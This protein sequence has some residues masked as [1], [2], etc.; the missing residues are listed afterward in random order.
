MMH[1]IVSKILTLAVMASAL[2]LGACKPE[3]GRAPAAPAPKALFGSKMIPRASLF[4]PPLQYQGRISP[5][6][7]KVSWLSLR[8]GAL[9][10]FI[11]DA[12]KPASA[13]QITHSKNG[14]GVH[15][16]SPN[17]AFIVFTE[18]LDNNLVK[19]WSLDVLSGERIALGPV[20]DGI[21]VFLQKVSGNWPNTALVAIN[22]RDPKWDDLYRINLSTG[23][24]KLVT[25]N[26]GFY[27]WVADDDLIPRIGIRKNKDKSDDWFLI[28]NDGSIK[29]LFHVLPQDV[30]GT[31]PLRFDPSG[32]VLYM[33]DQRQ[34]EHRVFSS[35]NLLDGREKI[36]AEMPGLSIDGVLFHPVT[37]RPLAWKAN[38]LLPMWVAL[39][40]DFSATLAFIRQALG[41]NFSILGTT[42]DVQ[43][44]V[45]YSNQPDRPGR[46]SLLDRATG[47]ISTMFETASP[48]LIPAQSS[49]RAVHI[50][51]KDGF[52]LI[53]YFSPGV[54]T[55]QQ[56]SK[57]PMIIM[58]QSLLGSRMIY[59]YSAQIPW[60]NSR[61]YSVLELNTRGASGLGPAYDQQ[62]TGTYLEYA[63]DDLI[64]AANWASENG[65]ADKDKIATIATE[66][67]GL[68]VL[69]AMRK[70]PPVFACAVTVNAITDLAATLAQHKRNKMRQSFLYARSFLQKNAQLDT[71]LITRL[72]P[73]EQSGPI[74]VPLL[75]VHSSAFATTSFSSAV[76]FANQLQSNGTP[77]T[78]ANI[79]RDT[80]SHHPNQ[81]IPP[82][83]V[84]SEH[85]LSQCLGGMAEPIGN[86]LE[87]TKVTFAIGAK[88]LQSLANILQQ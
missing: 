71:K 31:M 46:Y 84:I 38:G 43:R 2:G 88:H 74:T 37:N 49:A 53:G 40:T 3:Q 76:D 19:T 16:W 28:L 22:D 68:N 70:D 18:Q 4:Q 26:S 25:K 7:R 23:Q 10:L 79:Q 51:T 75:M 69:G 78:L 30:R 61:G 41:P 58:P 80:K 60:L 29:H 59:G 12:N 17:S 64:R 50:P 20:E 35:L 45:I 83:L 56:A 81:S 72:S 54:Q 14:I 47:Q 9:N 73:R 1:H 11:A 63:A 87:G 8:D 44:L 85:F 13:R 34:R 21:N 65:W 42:S 55:K 77:V 36:L 33:L 62:R 82:A 48:A 86:D 32:T 39:E 5:N 24:R 27:R 15:Y 66:F 6:G 57:R 67:G 52:R